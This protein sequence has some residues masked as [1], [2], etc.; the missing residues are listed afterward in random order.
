MEAV[1]PI[2]GETPC[3]ARRSLGGATQYPRLGASHRSISSTSLVEVGT[4]HEGSIG[5]CVDQLV[6]L[7]GIADVEPCTRVLGRNQHQLAIEQQIAVLWAIQN[8]FLD[9]VPVEK[10]KDFQARFMDFLATRRA[11]LLARLTAWPSVSKKDIDERLE[12]LAKDTGKSPAERV[13]PGRSVRCLPQSIRLVPEH[14]F[15]EDTGNFRREPVR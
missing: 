15:S 11:E 4:H 2:D 3:A 13:A 12:K 6:P 7:H 8:G 10:I 9:D 1:D 14:R 5:Q